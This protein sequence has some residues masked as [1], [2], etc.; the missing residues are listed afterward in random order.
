MAL[1]ERIR[2]A[3]RYQRS[4]RI[5]T[6]IGDP[7]ALDGFICPRSSAEVLETMARHV[8]KNG[9]GAFTWTGPYGSGKSSLVVVLSAAL[10]VKREFQ[11]DMESVLGLKTAALI[12]KAFPR[13]RRGWRI[14]PVV[15]RR[16]RAAQV[17]GESIM[18][19]DFLKVKGPPLQSWTDKGVLNALDTIAMRNPRAGGGLMVFIDEMGK[20]LEAA[21]KD[22]SD[23]FLFQELAERASRSGNRLIVV[24][25]LHQAFEEYAHRLSREMRNEWSK[26]QGRF[27]DLAVN[28]SGDEQIDLLGRA[29][30]SDNYPKKLGSLA[31]VVAAQIQRQTSPYFENMLENCWP[32]HPIVACL[33][34]PISRR[35]FGQNQRSIFG[36]LN[37]AEP[38]G[39]QDFLQQA[40]DDDLYGPDRLW[41]YLRI[42][43]EP[44][45]LA[46]PDG[47]RWALA[48]NALEQCEGR[49][50][51]G[52]H[53]RML[54]VIAALDMFKDRSG[55]C[56]SRDLLQLALPVN[57][58]SEIES[59]L[60]DL[61]RWSF[62]TYRKFTNAYS[63]FEG[64]DFD[65][66][67][68]VEKNWKNF[69]ELDFASLN[70]L[71]GL[72]PIVAK[73]HYHDTGA[74][75]WF[76][77]SIVPVAEILKIAEEYEPRHGAIGSFFLTIPTQGESL[78]TARKICQSAV[79][80]NGSWDIV[81]GFAQRA[82]E[83]PAQ[84][85]ELAV[86]KQVRKDTQKLLGDRVARIEVEARIAEVQELL[87]SE[88]VRA[89]SSA[90]WYRKDAA[91][92]VLPQAGLNR[93]A[94]DIADVRFRCAPKLHNEL[95]G[96]MKPSS[97]A[98]AARNALLRRM[99]LR[100]GEKRLGIVGF[101]AEGGLFVSLLEA[102][103]LYQKTKDGWC[104]VAP[105]PDDNG[106]HNLEPTWRKAT[107]L[108]KTNAHRAV[109]ISEIYDKW[110]KDPFGIKKG[111]L[112]VLAVAYLLSHRGSL[113]FYRE[114]IF[115]AH[116]S[117]LDIDYLAKDPSCVQL[118]WMDLTEVSRRHLSEMAD[119]VRELDEENRLSHLTPIDVARGLVAIYD[120]IPPWVARTQRLSGNAKRIRQLFKQA[121]D[122]NRLIFN[123]IPEIVKEGSVS[124]ETIAIDQVADC[125]REGLKELLQA[126]PAMLNRMR[127]TLLAELQVPNTSASTLRELRNRAENIR[128]LGGN[129]RLEAFIVRLARFRGAEED[130]EGLAGMAVNKPPRDWVDSDLDRATV[131][132]ADMAQRFLRA[133]AFA[134][135]KGRQDKRHAM[136]VV[137]SMAGQ[138]KLVHGEFEITEL[139]EPAVRAL[140]KKIDETLQKNGEQSRSII[141]AALAELSAQCLDSATMTNQSATVNKSSE[142]QEAIS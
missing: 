38:H 118:R 77:L 92:K 19:N 111:L 120:R 119:I 53:I 20:F 127:E 94:S 37:S 17:I 88:I 122:P 41:D 47:H 73:R 21:A 107:N 55:L 5:D 93:L 66:D 140:I 104:F 42:N 106:A 40:N 129:H 26:I 84:M 87:A 100:E 121:N 105:R 130:M 32:L 51:E 82:W 131:E 115:R 97:A 114:G 101:S 39:F 46:S 23:I 34:G 98:V 64:S 14:L 45:I 71:A 15:G 1:A 63:I 7:A 62:I 128:W 139:D 123:D 60:E 132:L 79:R 35:R 68:A 49:R 50:G 125:I 108:L 112:P 36:F 8:I 61:Q 4:I 22:G 57:E 142:M 70:T 65:I 69:G 54:K 99:V 18:E 31:K 12:R 58:P 90:P 27:V 29:I 3:R 126:Y 95:L 124:N 141:L 33:L 135:V 16:E 113:A 44:S 89:L 2:V 86:L 133:E 10:N 109:R 24:G 75:R 81:V 30:E 6:D 134:R 138:P 48:V 52:L 137:V 72:Q 85:R 102:T 74:L 78:E 56:A 11:Q 9:Q 110:C 43:L 103:G 136:A 67:R 59:V 83:I 116:I 25:I 117:D 80:K 91:A 28:T 96:R 13:R 76:D